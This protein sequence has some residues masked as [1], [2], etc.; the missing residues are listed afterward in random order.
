MNE[1]GAFIFDVNTLY[2]HRE[3]L[4]NNTFVYETDSV[5]CV[6][7]NA[8]NEE[9]ASVNIS[10]DF[11][12]VQEDGSYERY[13]E[14]FSEYFYDDNVLTTILGKN[15]FKV[16]EKYDDFTLNPVNDKTQRI[17]YVCRKESK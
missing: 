5:Y 9:N 13:D 11:F 16:L 12:E 2:K 6:W 17:V 8:Y 14:S 7:Q 4:G 10:L 15:G 3:I 1:G